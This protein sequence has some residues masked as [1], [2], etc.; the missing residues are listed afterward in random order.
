MHKTNTYYRACIRLFL[1]AVVLFFVWSWQPAH[2]SEQ[3]RPCAREIATY[4]KGVKPGGGRL[5]KCL[6]EH[7]KDLSA[8]CREKVSAVDK[9]VKE[10][11]EA[12]AKDIDKFCKDV[13][14]GEGRIIRCLREHAQEISSGCSEKIESAKQMVRG[15]K[16][17]NR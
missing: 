6:K 9:K 1:S 8:T 2:A 3:T 15:G 16:T 4:C 12:C 11:Q 17:S 5:L 14:P 10:A 7:N 13:R